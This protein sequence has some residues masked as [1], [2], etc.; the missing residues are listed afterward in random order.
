MIY[1]WIILTIVSLITLLGTTTSA[2]AEEGSLPLPDPRTISVDAATIK[3]GTMIG[4]AAGEVVIAVPPLALNT[5][6]E[7]N[8]VFESLETETVPEGWEMVQPWSTNLTWSAVSMDDA[9]IIGASAKTKKIPVKKPT[10]QLLIPVGNFEYVPFIARWDSARL[11][12]TR[13]ATVIRWSNEEVSTPLDTM[14]QYALFQDTK[15]H[16]TGRA[17]WYPDRLSK[18][19]SLAAAS[20][21]YP[22]RTRLKVTNIQTKESVIVTVQSVGPFVKGRIIDLTKTAFSKIGYPRKQGVLTVTVEPIFSNK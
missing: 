22:L 5:P 21:E 6:T 16:L 1:R 15:H 4:S 11:R 3:R 14:G 18:D 17:T 19:S 2:Q 8:M 7:I 13:L 10:M 9:E 12:W 20:N